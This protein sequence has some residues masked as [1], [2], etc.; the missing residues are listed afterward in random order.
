MLST[1]VPNMTPGT[2]GILANQD[3]IAINQDTLGSPVKLVQRFSN[4]HDVFAGPL[5]NGNQ[6]IL[7]LEQSDRVR[8]LPVN[9]ADLGIAFADVNDF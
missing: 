8:E 6:A 3:L 5:A 4:D 2:R 9:F 7:L 1:N